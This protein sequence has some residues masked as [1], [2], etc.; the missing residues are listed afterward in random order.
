MCLLKEVLPGPPYRALLLRTAG[1][2]PRVLGLALQSSGYICAITS[3][4]KG[5]FHV[6]VSETLFLS[7]SKEVS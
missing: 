1:V 6:A 5:C 4:C 7:G 2:Q 3:E